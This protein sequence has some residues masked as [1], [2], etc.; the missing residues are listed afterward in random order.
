M[1]NCE[2]GNQN[3]VAQWC[4]EG[5]AEAAARGPVIAS[6]SGRDA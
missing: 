4:E 1:L 6:V 2:W 5:F 3:G